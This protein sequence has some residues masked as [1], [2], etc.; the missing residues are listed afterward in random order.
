MKIFI[1]VIIA[2][3]TL[4]G[5]ADCAEES[6]R[7]G[8]Y[9]SGFIGASV[10]RD[11]N[12]TSEQYSTGN[13]FY[14]KVELYPG[15][16]IGVTG[17]YNF[18]FFRLEGEVSYK[19]GEIDEITDKSDNYRFQGVEGDLAVFA[20]MCNG[21]FD[22]R[23]SSPVTPYFGGGVGVATV[24][25]GDTFGTDTRDGIITRNLLYAEDADS[26]LAYQVGGG[27]EIALNSVL[28]LDLSYRYFGTSKAR[29]KNDWDMRTE[30]KFESHNAAVGLRVKF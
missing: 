21:F 7:R 15:S 17:G 13:T 3:V 11:A 29:F 10:A 14:D 19:S 9:M 5:T 8:A 24:Y 25:L 20:V 1:T 30:L 26:V 28:S 4:A 6:L 27:V 18:G 23:N 16:N 2:L 22:L 12:V